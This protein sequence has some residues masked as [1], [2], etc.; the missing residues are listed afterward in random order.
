MFERM[1][2]RRISRLI[3]PEEITTAVLDAVR[4]NRWSVCLP[5][6]LSPALLL[7]DVPRRM[8]WFFACGLT[9]PPCVGP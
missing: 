8:P 6:R 7:A 3:R 2:R 9:T 5:R 1:Y 4:D